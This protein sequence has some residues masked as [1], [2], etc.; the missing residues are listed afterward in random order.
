MTVEVTPV[1]MLVGDEAIA[2]AREDNSPALETDEDG[3]DFLPN[4]YYLH[5]FDAS[6]RRT[7]PLSPTC[8]ITVVPEDGSLET[9]RTV[10]PAEL[11]E[12]VAVYERLMEV[13]L[14]ATGTEITSLTEVYLP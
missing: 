13:G 14:N 3:K 9:D 5:V 7:L 8:V 11:A 6:Q 10:T 4:D 1:E 12:I 2:Q